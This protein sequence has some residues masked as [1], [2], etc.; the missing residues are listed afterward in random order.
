MDFLTSLPAD[1]AALADP[2]VR[3]AAP[4]LRPPDSA[5]E[6]QSPTTPFALCLALLTEPLSGGEAWPATG[7]ELPVVPL[8]P[9]AEPAAPAR[10]TRCSLWRQTRSPPP[11]CK[12]AYCPSTRPWRGQ[13]RR[14]PTW[15]CWDVRRRL[16]RSCYR[17]WR[18]ARRPSTRS[19]RRQL[20]ASTRS[21]R[22]RGSRPRRSPR[23][24]KLQRNLPRVLRPRR[25]RPRAGSKP[26]PNSACS[27]PRR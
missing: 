12:R 11:H 18:A 3:G 22:W 7:K 26:L 19:Q 13:P 25:R 4:L 9:A 23:R 6:T 10:R 17:R 16:P 20:P 2:S 27:G 15:P 14:L 8:E 24:S 5:G 1:L 21:R